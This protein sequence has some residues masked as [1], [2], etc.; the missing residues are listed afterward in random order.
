MKSIKVILL[1]LALGQFGT[2]ATA[3]TTDTLLYKRFTN[4]PPFNLR[5]VPDSSVLNKDLL[6][7]N[8]PTLFFIFSPDC[9]HCQL[10]TAD[11]LKH[12]Q[13]FKNYQIIM[14]SP[15]E[16]KWILPFYQEFKLKNYPAIKI[17]RDASNMLGTFFNVHNFP[18]LFLYNKKGEFVKEFKGNIN[19]QEIYNYLK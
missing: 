5:L 1:V 13:L 7:K 14:A 10:T 3:Q 19:F 9:G 2:T 8:K 4:T 18:E 12:Y 17:G 6:K 11:L 16:Y 15:I